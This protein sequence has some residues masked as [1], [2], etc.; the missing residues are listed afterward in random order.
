MAHNFPGTP[1]IGD[2]SRVGTDYFKWDGTSWV[3]QNITKRMNILEYTDSTNTT[4]TSVTIDPN[5][6]NY[7]LINV[8]GNT[9]ITLPTDAH[10]YSSVI[11]EL[12]YD[13]ARKWNSSL[14]TLLGIQPTAVTDGTGQGIT[15]KPD[16]TTMYVVGTTL[17]TVVPY[18]LSTPWDITTTGATG[19]S[20]SVAT[21]D[22]AMRF[23]LFNPDGTRMYLGGST[24]AAIH[25]YNLSTAWNVTTAV[26]Q[27]STTI[28]LSGYGAAFNPTG[29]V[30]YIVALNGTINAYTLSTAWDTTTLNATPFST[31][32]VSA[33]EANSQ[34][35]AFSSDGT[36]MY[37]YGQSTVDGIHEFALSTPWDI[38]T[39]TYTSI[40]STSAEATGTA[41]YFKPNG[42]G[43][44]VFGSTLDKVCQYGFI[45]NN[46]NIWVSWSNNIY[47]ATAP[48][49]IASNLSYRRLFLLTT[50]DGIDW[51]GMP[52]STTL[53]GVIM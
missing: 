40:G 22:G 41:F 31:F 21:Q 23:V 27:A 30:I 29:D 16:G 49:T 20:F 52:L 3:R 10:P 32:S 38:T 53:Q 24:T 9:A 28:P 36:K 12:N 47:W 15:F 44:Y 18:T 13:E 50:Y 4:A 43:V 39:A 51:V 26:F 25:Q 35:I 1:N 48:D 5:T 8:S 2:F 6:Y 46:D 42:Y 17:D 11:V 33:Y 37:I 7:Y 45:N 14:V 34:D 19:A